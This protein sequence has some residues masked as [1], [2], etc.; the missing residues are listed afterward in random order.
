[1]IDDTDC[2]ES[3]EIFIAKL[4]LSVGRSKARLF[5]HMISALMIFVAVLRPKFETEI[6]VQD[7]HPTR[8]LSHRDPKKS[9]LTVFL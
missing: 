2:E 3:D 7:R 1:L 9:N 4:G 6:S 8:K 5:S